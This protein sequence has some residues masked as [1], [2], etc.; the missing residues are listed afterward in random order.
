MNSGSAFYADS[1]GVGSWTLS[2]SNSFGNETNFYPSSSS[3]INSF[4]VDPQMGSCKL[5]LPDNSPMKGAGVGGADIGANIL[6]AYENGVLTSNKL[7]N[8]DGS[9][10]FSGVI[11][12]GVNDIPGSLFDI[13]NRLNINTNGCAFPARI[14]NQIMPDEV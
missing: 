10:A 1:T 4:S 8:T 11:V 12:P 14:F 5:W 3:L 2:F 9:F 6:Y 7:W 13:Q